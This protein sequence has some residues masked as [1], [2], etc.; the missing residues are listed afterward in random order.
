MTIRL[1]AMVL[2][3]LGIALMTH[4]IVTRRDTTPRRVRR[5]IM[6][7]Y[8]ILLVVGYGLGWAFAHEVVVNPA[9]YWMTT[10]LLGLVASLVWHPEG[11]DELPPRD[12]SIGTKFLRWL[13]KRVKR[14]KAIREAR[15]YQSP[16]HT[17]QA[18]PAFWQPTP[19]A[20]RQEARRHPH[21]GIRV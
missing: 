7:L 10:G 11:D 5:V 21:H 13:D 8:F 9:V 15:K 18:I 14:Q 20:Q 2:V 12:N 19:A 16:K 3:A 1:I 6:W 4:T 17:P